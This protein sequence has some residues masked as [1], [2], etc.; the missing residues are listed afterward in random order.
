MRCPHLCTWLDCYRL[1][2]E[3]VRRLESRTKHLKTFDDELLKKNLEE[4]KQ[5]G[6]KKQKEENETKHD[7][8]T[9]EG[10]ETE[11]GEEMEQS[12]EMEQNEN[13]EEQEVTEEAVPNAE[14]RE[15]Q[16]GRTEGCVE[17]TES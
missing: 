1:R 17:T 14:P 13:S 12:G 8:E 11:D 16:W 2:D 5:R 10:Q 9:E 4:R 6:S 15:E 3:W 7:T